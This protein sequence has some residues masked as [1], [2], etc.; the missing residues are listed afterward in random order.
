MTTVKVGTDASVDVRAGEQVTLEVPG[1]NTTGYLWHLDANPKAVEV[2][3]HEIVADDSSFGGGGLERFVVRP[4]QEGP[5]TVRLNL[6]APWESEPVETHNVQV[7][8]LK[9]NE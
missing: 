9:P 3:G 1:A 2:L 5:A 4:L 7:R 6:K 8:L